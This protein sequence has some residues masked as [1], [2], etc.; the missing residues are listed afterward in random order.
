M[1][2]DKNI[3]IN[4]LDWVITFNWV[5]YIDTGLYYAKFIII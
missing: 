4:E 1:K 2:I 3:K 5:N